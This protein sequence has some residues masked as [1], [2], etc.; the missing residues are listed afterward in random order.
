MDK[1]GTITLWKPAAC[2]MLVVLQWAAWS[3]IG[4]DMPSPAD[5]NTPDSPAMTSIAVD[6]SAWE[7]SAWEASHQ[8]LQPSRDPHDATA[9]SGFEYQREKHQPQNRSTSSLCHQL[10]DWPLPG[11]SLG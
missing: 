3:Q 9:G 6:D 7:D 8:D 1:N 4:L 2:L 11:C 10:Q 5:T